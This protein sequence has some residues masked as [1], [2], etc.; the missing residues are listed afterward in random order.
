MYLDDKQIARFWSYVD[1]RSI[2]ECWAWKGTVDHDGYAKFSWKKFSLKAHR[3]MYELVHDTVIYNPRICVCH[4][5]D[6]R[7]CVNPSHLFLTD[8]RGNVRDMHEKDRGA[9]AIGQGEGFKKNPKVKYIR[10]RKYK[11]KGGVVKP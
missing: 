10:D 5:C 9:I 6:D 2:T 11:K 4:S 7:A 1:R 8:H 3:V